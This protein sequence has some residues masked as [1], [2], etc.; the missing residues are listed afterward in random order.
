MRDSKDASKMS[1]WELETYLLIRFLWPSNL[2]VS[3]TKR[4]L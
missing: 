3:K 2:A 1:S 4:M